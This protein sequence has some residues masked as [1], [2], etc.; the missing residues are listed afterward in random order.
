MLFY[1]PVDFRDFGNQIISGTYTGAQGISILE[2]V[3]GQT[4]ESLDLDSQLVV[5]NSFPSVVNSNPQLYPSF[6]MLHGES[7]SLLPSRQSER[8]CDALGGML[9]SDGLVEGNA[10]GDDPDA[11]E[12]FTNVRTSV[13]CDSRGSQLHL[14]AQGEHTL[15]LCLS[16]ELCLSGSPTS[17]AATADVI[18]S[19]LDWSAADRLIAFDPDTRAGTGDIGSGRLDGNSVG[20]LALLWILR[21][22]A[23][24]SGLFRRRSYL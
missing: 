23:I 5:D 21:W 24:Q 13:A 16:D 19:M 9:D 1:A 14:I 6:F 7:D 18:Q 10:A 20:L 2:S 3:T 17:A 11:D 4:T 8:L 22:C 12:S 15:D